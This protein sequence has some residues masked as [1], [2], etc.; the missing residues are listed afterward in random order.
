M[1]YI[2]IRTLSAKISKIL[3][4]F[5]RKHPEMIAI[6]IPGQKKQL[7]SDAIKFYKDNGLVLTYIAGLMEKYP[8]ELEVFGAEK[9]NK[10]YLPNIVV[11]GGK[12][13]AEKN[14]RK[15]CDVAKNIGVTEEELKEIKLGTKIPIHSVKDEIEEE[16]KKV[17]EKSNTL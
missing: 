5:E 4:D 10:A 17:K 16:R 15:F 7:Y 8:G 2:I 12:W 14:H 1:D 6:D 3:Y 13:L 9:I 11:K